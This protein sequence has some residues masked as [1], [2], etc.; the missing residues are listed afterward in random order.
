[1]SRARQGAGPAA[2]IAATAGACLAFAAGSVHAK[3]PPSPVPADA[4]GYATTARAATPSYNACVEPPTVSYTLPRDAAISDQD[5]MNCFAW[6][7]FI[8][9]N[10]QASATRNGQPDT[11]VT[12]ASF[13]MPAASGAPAPTVWETYALSSNVFRKNAAQPLPFNGVNRKAGG[14][15]SPGTT[16]FVRGAAAEDALTDI[17]QAFIKTWITAQ[18]GKPT[19]YEKR[20]NVEEYDYIVGNR[21]YD[22]SAQWQRIADGTGI[23]LPDGSADGT[24]GAIEIKAAWLPLTDPSLYARYLTRPAT[25]IDPASGK[26][27]KAVVGLVGLHIIHKTRTAQQFTWATFE[28]VDNVPVQGQVG[29]GPYTYYNPRCNPAS[30]PYQCQV[31]TAPVCTGNA[32]DYAQP[33]QIARVE[34]IRDDV[35]ALNAYVQDVIRGANPKSVMQYYQLISVMWPS[36]ST[37]ISGTPLAPL[38]AG[39]PQPPNGVGG[40]ANAVLETYF[41]TLN[42]ASPNPLLTQPNCLACHTVAKLPARGF[43]PDWGNR[44][45]TYASDYSFLFSEAEARAAASLVAAPCKPAAARAGQPK[46]RGCFRRKP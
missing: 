18:N 43:P 26:R 8:A 44:P 35:A 28:Q 31:N 37:P 25:L 20:M 32:C 39:T 10:W 11:S 42:S 27:E 9:L 36:S 3:A 41:Q 17:L 5:D 40:L 46:D 4:S 38:T 33:T 21:L 7:Q 22:A 23:Q 16:G 24:V 34:P 1:M 19:Y 14:R 30:D 29:A 15:A 13:G 12:A 6:Q 2:R 45:K